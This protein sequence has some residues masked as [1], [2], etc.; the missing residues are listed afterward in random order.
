LHHLHALLYRTCPA[1]SVVGK[2]VLAN[3]P[4]STTAPAAATG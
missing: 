2:F 4:N 1:D 3:D